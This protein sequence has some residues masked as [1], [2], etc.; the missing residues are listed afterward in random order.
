MTL[1]ETLERIRSQPSLSGDEETAK[2]KLILPVVQALGWDIHGSEVE[3][4]YLIKPKRPKREDRHRKADVALLSRS[5]Q[6][7]AFIEA[8]AV[9]R[10]LGG[11]DVT[12]VVRYA[13]DKRAGD[14]SI[15]VLT[16]GHDWWLYL[17]PQQTQEGQPSDRKFRNLH[18]LDNTL[19]Y[20]EDD[21]RAFLDREAL[22]GG[23]AARQARRV[24]KAALDADRLDKKLP[25][26]W[27]TLTG[28]AG[29]SRPHPALISLVTKLV[30]EKEGLRPDSEQVAEM[31]RSSTGGQSEEPDDSP[32][33]DPPSA[34]ASVRPPESPFQPSPPAMAK[35]PQRTQRVPEFA[36]T[37]IV[38]YR[39]WNRPYK[40][41]TNNYELL[42]KVCLDI[43]NEGHSHDFELIKE[44]LGRGRPYVST[45]PEE[46]D[47]S[48]TRQETRRPVG[49]TGW[50]VN[51]NL[52]HHNLEKRAR[53]F[54]ERLNYN[55]N[56][57]KVYRA[58][59]APLAE[60]SSSR[61]GN[62]QQGLPTGLIGFKLWDQHCT[63]KYYYE[64]ARAV[65]EGIYRR[66]PADFQRAETLGG[67]ILSK[68]PDA[69]KNSEQV[70][71][72]GWYVDVSRKGRKHVRDAEKLLEHFDYKPDDLDVS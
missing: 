70:A 17:S 62:R 54:L 20:L 39:L 68:D 57:L 56:D 55:P 11:R 35:L 64:I 47:P 33:P 25:G 18:L 22:V 43:Y 5:G 53:L 63:A 60:A 2:M 15:C 31:L 3:Y 51:A 59:E 69:F 27:K 4:E 72:S 21:L 67:S 36:V 30:Y 34:P 24:L 6:P 71:E 28:Q 61:P 37:K 50:Y 45:Q 23:K 7:V 32:P 38:G 52:T 26:I 49:S 13:T 66:N 8:K 46:L 19:E 40:E 44:P 12:Q 14:V 1:R 65:A 42:T 9:G 16:N 29:R 48:G 10:E 41:V 58:G